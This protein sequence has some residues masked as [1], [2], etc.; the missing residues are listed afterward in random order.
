MYENG[1]LS[2]KQPPITQAAKE[3]AMKNRV[4]RGGPEAETDKV[5]ATSKFHFSKGKYGHIVLAWHGVLIQKAKANF[6][7]IC[8]Q[9]RKIF[10]ATNDETGNSN[11]VAHIDPEVRTR[12]GLESE[13]ESESGV[14]EDIQGE[15]DHGHE[16]VMKTADT[17]ED[18]GH[19]AMD[20]EMKI[21]DDS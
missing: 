17:A 5:P 13:P 11:Q 8:A 14:E 1:A 2:L 9:A 21:S 20:S 19:D 6:P 4:A 16:I 18:C 7:D 3:R 15:E 12:V 10:G